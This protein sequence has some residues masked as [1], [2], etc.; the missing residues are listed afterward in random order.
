MLSFRPAGNEIRV[1]QVL[2]A[3]CHIRKHLPIPK[4]AN[5][6]GLLYFMLMKEKAKLQGAM[7]VRLV[8]KSDHSKICTDYMSSDLYSL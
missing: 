3:N 6:K 7:Y 2:L 4:L 5:V 8:L 1:A